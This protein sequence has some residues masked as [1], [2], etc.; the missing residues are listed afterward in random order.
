MSRTRRLGL[1]V[2]VV[3]GTVFAEVSAG[4]G[5]TAS[6]DEGEVVSGGYPSTLRMVVCP[7]YDIEEVRREYLPLVDVLQRNLG[8]RV[9]LQPVERARRVADALRRGDVD[10]AVLSVGTLRE[11]DRR[12]M[13]GDL[14]IVA[15]QVLNNRE[16]YRGV[17]VVR[18]GLRASSLE[19]LRGRTLAVPDFRSECAWYQIERACELAGTT[20]ARLFGAVEQTGGHDEALRA[21]LDGDVDAAAVSEVALRRAE[22]EGEPV[23]SLV[24]AHQTAQIPFDGF[25]VSRRLPDALRRAVALAVL[26]F[27]ERTP[28]Q[29]VVMEWRRATDA[30]YVP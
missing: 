13:R 26:A 22:A 14:E 29:G 21:V 15:A 16:R 10:L 3:L 2:A 30:T 27:K 6:A 17:V 28:V 24:Q 5:P 8:V 23:G 12:G 9:R 11:L 20:P 7:A 1:F 19:D 25:F 18:H 4:A